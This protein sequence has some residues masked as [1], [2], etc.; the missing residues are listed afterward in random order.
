MTASDIHS[1]W[2]SQAACQ[3]ADRELFFPISEVAASHRNIAEAKAVCGQ[4]LVRVECLAHAI[5][6]GPVQGIW[7]GTTENERRLMR[8]R[9]RKQASAVR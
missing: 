7:G 4:C 9:R 1:A 8:S 5:G 2:W 3:S 6:S